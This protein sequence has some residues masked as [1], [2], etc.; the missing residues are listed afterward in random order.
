[1]TDRIE[2]KINV[3][4]EYPKDLPFDSN[5]YQTWLIGKLKEVGIPIDGTFILK[6][7]KR[8]RLTR[9]TDTEDFSTDIYIWEDI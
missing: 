4:A 3:Q 2:V 9:L 8:G 6:G 5:S 1:M 7:L